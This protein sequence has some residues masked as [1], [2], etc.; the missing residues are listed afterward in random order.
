MANLS[1]AYI[2]APECRKQ[3]AI[4]I[5]K[6]YQFVPRVFPT[7]FRKYHIQLLNPGLRS[8]GKELTFTFIEING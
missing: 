5:T 3:K 7:L 8:L 1:N 4:H 6:Q 2:N